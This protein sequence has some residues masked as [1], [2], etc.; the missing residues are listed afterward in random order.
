MEPI[1][2]NFRNHYSPEGTSARMIWL[3]DNPT[4]CTMTYSEITPDA[5]SA[6]HIHP[7]EHE[8]YIIKGSGTLVCDGKE[9]PVK[10]GD[11]ILI[12]GEVDHYTLNN[13]GDGVIRRIEINP[14][15]A[16]QTGGARTGET[17]NGK[18]PMIRNYRDLGTEPGSRLIGI[19]D[20][21]PTYVMLYNGAMSP[22][23]VSHASEGGHSHEWDHAVFILEGNG[24]IVCDG[25]EFAV[26]EGD[27]VLVPPNSFHQWRNTSDAPMLRV[28]FNALAADLAEH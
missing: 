19:P 2:R 24:T 11:G 16:A 6:H 17:G 26:A 12:P 1:I 25:K 28:T 23:A 15:M 22:G 21:A 4:T 27:S 14:L 8:V 18:P 9:F 3:D 10:E 7:W 13:G 20:G 5:T